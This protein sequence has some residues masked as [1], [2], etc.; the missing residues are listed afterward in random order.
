MGRSGGAAIAVATDPPPIAVRVIPDPAAFKKFLLENFMFKPPHMNSTLG[1]FPFHFV[2]IN[3]H[4]V[5]KRELVCPV[6]NRV[7]NGERAVPWCAMLCPESG[8]EKA[9]VGAVAD[10]KD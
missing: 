6:L 10:A 7:L 4:I 9:L 1:D 2:R 3:G 8:L 5:S